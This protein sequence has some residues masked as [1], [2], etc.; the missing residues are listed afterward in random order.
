M[1]DRYKRS[2]QHHRLVESHWDA[3]DEFINLSIPTKPERLSQSATTPPA[4]IKLV[5]FSLLIA[6]ITKLVFERFKNGRKRDR[7][8]MSR[9]TKRRQPQSSSAPTSS[10]LKRTKLLSKS[11]TTVMK[12]IAKSLFVVE[13]KEEPVVR[14]PPLV[15]EA[16]SVDGVKK[17]E[18]SNQ[19]V[20]SISTNLPESATEYLPT[21]EASLVYKEEESYVIINSSNKQQQQ[22]IVKEALKLAEQVKVASEIF[23]KQGL[24]PKSAHDFVLRRH[25][26]GLQERS[27]RD[28]ENQKLAVECQMRSVELEQTERRHRESISTQRRDPNGVPKCLAARDR[29]VEYAANAVAYLM[30]AL[31]IDRLCQSGMDTIRSELVRIL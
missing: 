8:V 29:V 2:K 13:A 4:F 16:L 24:D 26:S 5:I 23:E 17:E 25:L 11:N 6:A 20:E 30:L 10:P 14:E 12:E 21:K 27:R 19:K 1:R 3:E 31:A 15:K 7:K 28:Y 18:A 9:R 22:D